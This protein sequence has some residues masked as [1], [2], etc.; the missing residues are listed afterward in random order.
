MELGQFTYFGSAIA[1][2]GD[3][4]CGLAAFQVSQKGTGEA[5][6]FL[7]T[8]MLLAT[9]LAVHVLAALFTRE[10]VVVAEMGE[11]SE[12]MLEEGNPVGSV[13]M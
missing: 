6:F 1:V 12:A 9:L 3:D 13:S 11:Y 4:A 7:T 8:A 2:N 10:A 5:S